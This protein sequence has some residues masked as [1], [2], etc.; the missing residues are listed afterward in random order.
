VGKQ[1]LSKEADALQSLAAEGALLAEESAAGN[2][3]GIYTREQAA[4]LHA[5]S[6]QAA[7]A[8][9]RASAGPGLGPELQELRLL[10]T[11]VARDLERLG[12]ASRREQRAIAR[13]LGRAAKRIETI[14]NGLQ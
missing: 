4:A 13:R 6:L 1:A 12:H 8:L 2:A 5:A 7:D 10:A 9:K 3:T 11:R 14:A